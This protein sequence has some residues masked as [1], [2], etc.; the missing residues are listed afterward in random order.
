MSRHLARVAI[1]LLIVAG[2]VVHIGL[3][4]RFGLLI[5]GIGLVGH[6][7]LGAAARKLLRRKAEQVKAGQRPWSSSTR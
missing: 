4:Y 1:T 5:A 3:G 2:I 6:L 7:V